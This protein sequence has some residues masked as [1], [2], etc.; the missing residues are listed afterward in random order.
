MQLDGT[1]RRLPGRKAVFRSVFLT[2]WHMALYFEWRINKKTHSFRLFF[3]NFV[4]WV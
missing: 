1:Q 4:H 3:G 2:T